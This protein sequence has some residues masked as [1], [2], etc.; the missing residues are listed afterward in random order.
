MRRGFTN[1]KIY[2]REEEAFLIEDNRIARI[3]TNSE[4]QKELDETDELID[5]NG[6]FVMPGFID[7]H[8]HLLETGCYLSNVRLIGL[9]TKEEIAAAVKEHLEEDEVWIEGRGYDIEIDRAFLDEIST[10]KAIVLTRVCGHQITVNSKALELAGIDEDTEVQDGTIDFEKGILT[11]NAVRLISRAI[12]KLTVEKIKNRILTAVQY[13]NTYGITAVG[14]DDFLCAGDDYKDVLTAFEQLSYQGKLNLRVV[15]QCE[16]KDEKNYSEFL[17]EGYTQGVG[18]EFFQIGPLKLIADG[19]L[20]AKTAAVVIPY[21]NTDE[22]GELIYTDDQMRLYVQL[23]NRFNMGVIIH[24]IGDRALD[25]VLRIFED[26]VYEGNPLHDGIVHCQLMR[27]DQTEKVKELNLCCYFQSLFI[28]DDAKMLK[29][30]VDESLFETSYPYR[31]LL[32]SVTASNGSDSPVCVP[33][34]LKGIH[35]AVTRKASDG[36]SMTQSECLTVKEAVDS[37][38]ICGAQNLQLEELGKIEEGYLADFVVLDLEKENIRDAAV[39]MTVVDGRTV[40]EK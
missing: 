1:C 11:E 38:T 40:Y 3:G 39:M 5:L 10:E 33:D 26:E 2:G 6:L 25:Q 8:M 29:D 15:E 24:A 36:N 13:C 18:D 14:S 21:K 4:I 16:F 23:A 27:E 35:L 17:D 34:V 28:E 19:S 22:K 30:T 31:T 37:Y 12:P 7:S 9:H 32:R 20:G